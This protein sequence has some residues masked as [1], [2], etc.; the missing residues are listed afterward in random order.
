MRRSCVRAVSASGGA[1]EYRFGRGVCGAG[2]SGGIWPPGRAAAGGG[3][4]SADLFPGRNDYGFT[5][6]L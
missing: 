2:V 4:C 3:L 6:C 5:A 1:L